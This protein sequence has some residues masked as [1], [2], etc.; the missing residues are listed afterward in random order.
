M[1]NE[2]QIIL[3]NIRM[4][5]A[6]KTLSD[7]ILNIKSGQYDNSNN[8]SYYAMFYAIRAVLALENKDFKSH[9]Q[10]IGYFN[11][12]YINTGRFEPVF[13]DMIKQSSKSRHD[14]DYEDLYNATKEEA[15]KNAHNAELFIKAV[16]KYIENCIE[17]KVDNER[18]GTGSEEVLTKEKSN[19]M[20]L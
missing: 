18:Q 3:S 15:E 2:K 11:K 10:L 16:E 6:N 20:G 5:K 4:E 9:G 1:L 8:R 17:R 14:S 12:A 19:G 13:K 7:A